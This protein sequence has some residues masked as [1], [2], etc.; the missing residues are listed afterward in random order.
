M[1]EAPRLDADTQQTEAG[2][3]RNMRMLADIPVR[4]SV[5]VGSTQLR[6]A[7]IMALGEGSVVQ[8]DRQADELLDIMVNGTLVARGEVVTVNG[9]YG[10][11]VVE[12]A[13]AE[14]RLLG[15]ERRA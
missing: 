5:E 11:R 14:T 1:S 15:L 6:L 12:I 13:S 9:R 10:I 8:L 7:E 2:L 4:M 3:G